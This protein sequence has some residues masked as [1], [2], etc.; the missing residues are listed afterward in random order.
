M[1]REQREND[2]NGHAKRRYPGT[3][4]FGSYIYTHEEFGETIDFI[5]DN[6][7]ELS[8]PHFQRDPTGGSAADVEDLAVQYEK[9]FKM[10]Y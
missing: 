5:H 9:L 10:H 7:L 4:K 8:G 6:K 2:R 3:E 1:D